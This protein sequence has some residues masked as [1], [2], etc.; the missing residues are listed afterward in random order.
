MAVLVTVSALSSLIVRAPG[1]GNTGA[2]FTSLT[3]TVKVLVALNG[4]EPLSVTMV[5]N[6]LVLGPCASP[7]VQVM[8]PLAS[9][10]APAGG[11][12]S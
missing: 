11:E 3:V 4:G 6:V 7:G 2:L 5:V 8:T 10:L 9:M 1:A 12:T